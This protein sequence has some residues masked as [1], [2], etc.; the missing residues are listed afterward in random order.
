[1]TCTASNAIAVARFS[2]SDMSLGSSSDSSFSHLKLSSL[3]RGGDETRRRGS[4]CR[5]LHHRRSAAEASAEAA[6]AFEEAGDQC[7]FQV[8]FPLT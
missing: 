6:V 3:E 7:G 4:N 1:M 5:A 2:G 8:D